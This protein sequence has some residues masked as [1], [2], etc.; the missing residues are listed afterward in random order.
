MNDSGSWLA[1]LQQALAAEFARAPMV[2]TL[3]TVDE[4]GLPAARCVICRRIEPTG[5]LLFISDARSR[6]NEHLAERPGAEVVFWLPGRQIQ[7]RIAGTVGIVRAG[8]AEDLRAEVWQALSDETRAMFF[9]PASGEPRQPDHAGFVR[10][11]P[12]HTAAPATF[13]LL[14]LRP[15]QVDIVEL[16]VLPHRRRLFIRDETGWTV[17]EINP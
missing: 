1:E 9:W 13:E 15:M 5:E 3:A 2:C 11:V 17:S 12:A 10:Q 4:H 7:F 14:L 8:M 6:K 16:A